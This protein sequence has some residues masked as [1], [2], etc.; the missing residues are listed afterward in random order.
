MNPLRP[1]GSLTGCYR[2]ARALRKVL[3][4]VE[5]E[6]AHPSRVLG[7]VR[8]PLKR[9]E[10]QRPIPWTSIQC[11]EEVRVDS[12]HVDDLS[13]HVECTRIMLMA[14]CAKIPMLSKK[15]STGVKSQKSCAPVSL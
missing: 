10:V 1:K 4:R 6:L 3:I 11:A 13:Q 9:A 7:A 5:R 2:L 12:K 14:P 15:K 8:I